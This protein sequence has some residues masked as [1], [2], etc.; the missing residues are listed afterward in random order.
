M[1][2]GWRGLEIEP[3]ILVGSLGWGAGNDDRVL[4]LRASQ[5]LTS[6]LRRGSKLFLALR[7]KETQW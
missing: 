5:S 4:T 7:A 3:V 6:E 1:V 2:A